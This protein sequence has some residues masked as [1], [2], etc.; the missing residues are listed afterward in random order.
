MIDI[1]EALELIGSSVKTIGTS[2]VELRHS[3]GRILCQPVIADV[4]SPPHTKSIMD[5]YAV[6]SKD[7]V[8][9]AELRLLETIIAGAVPTHAVSPGTCS[10]IM[11]GAPLPDGADAVVMV[12]QSQQI[13]TEQEISVK[14]S[15]ESIV[16]G[17]H[18][19]EKASSFGAGEKIFETGHQVRPLDIGL[20]S[21][22]GAHELVVAE[23]ITASVIPTGNELVGADTKP[24]PGQI[25]NSN[26]PML[27]SLMKNLQVD[28]CDLG[29]GRDDRNELGQLIEAGLQSDLLVLSGGVSAG[30]MDLVPALLKEAGVEQVFHKVRVKPGKP[31]WFGV[32]QTPTK[33]TYVFGLPGN[34]VSSLVGFELFVKAAIRKLNGC[35]ELRAPVTHA[36]LAASHEA[37]GDRPTYW[38]GSWVSDDSAVRKI[39]PLKWMGSSDLRSLGSA[40]ALIY[41][42]SDKNHFESGE[43]VQVLPV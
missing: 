41:F 42:P 29:V 19:M 31:I 7:V 33:S 10:R 34:P 14:F 4:D 38:P 21:E 6:R 25:R 16:A 2:T 11:T 24:G 15:L 37:R 12:E 20:L 18:V 36:E 28:T 26:G 30:T 8:P 35:D 22:V 27:V 43:I 39:R 1:E 9:G 32:R 23:K 5:G 13:E 3:V 40:D 17:K